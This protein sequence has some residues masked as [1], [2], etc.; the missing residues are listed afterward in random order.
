M[1]LLNR[2]TA[3]HGKYITRQFSTRFSVGGLYGTTPELIRQFSYV[4]IC[5]AAG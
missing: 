3:I 2:L 5:T 1:S 4:A